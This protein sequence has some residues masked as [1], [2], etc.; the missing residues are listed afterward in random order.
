MARIT[1]LTPEEQQEIRDMLED[2]I[3]CAEIAR[4]IGR[5]QAT[6]QRYRKIMG[7]P[8]VYCSMT[9]TL[10]K[11][12]DAKRYKWLQEHWHFKVANPK[13]KPKRKVEFHT[14]YNYMKF[15]KEDK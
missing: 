15:R 13:P 4:T 14:P 10:N 3:S 11:K 9:D 12:E 7:F 6:I 2:G 5:S 1:Y 8:P